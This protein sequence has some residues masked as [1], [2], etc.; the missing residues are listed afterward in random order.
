MRYLIFAALCF[1]ATSVSAQDDLCKMWG[2]GSLANQHCKCA[3][4]ESDIER[5]DCYE[6]AGELASVLAFENLARARNLAESESGRNAMRQ[7]LRELGD[8]VVP[9][10]E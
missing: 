7:A 2:L 4:I 9:Q 1:P 3:E 5:L 8:T 10:G 6:V